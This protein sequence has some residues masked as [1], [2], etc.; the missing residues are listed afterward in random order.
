MTRRLIVALADSHAGHKLGLLNPATTLYDE[1]E[2]GE[3]V[4]WTPQLTAYQTYLWE[5]YQK[6]LA[7]VKALAGTDPVIVLHN[8]DATQGNKYPQ[9]LVSTREADHVLIWVENLRPW[10]TSGFNLEAVRI[11]K[12]TAAHNQGEGSSEMLIA[13]QLQA[14]Y[15]AADLKC[16]YHGLLI[17]A[18]HFKLDYAHHG[19]GAGIRDWTKGNVARFYLRDMITREWKAGNF[20]PQVVLRAHYHQWLE[21]IEKETLRGQDYTFRFILLPSLCGLGE[22]GAQV[23]RSAFA[24]T[25][26]LVVFE[27][28]DSHLRRVIPLIETVDIRTQEHI[29]GRTDQSADRG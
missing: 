5:V 7:Q 18:E 8:G 22:H 4:A 1:D 24:I 17:V 14:A 6:C 20:P 11:V 28:D 19:A 15:P 9:Q 16:L 12:G 21:V 3:L 13:A 23:T 2:H 10:F 25:N 26:G 27:L 29:G